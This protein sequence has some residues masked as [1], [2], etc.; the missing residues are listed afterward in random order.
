MDK[1]DGVQ[2][3]DGALIVRYDATAAALAAL[4]ERLGGVVYDCTDAK[5]DKAARQDRAELVRLGS[6]LE[7]KRKELKAPYLEL[8]RTIDAKAEEY[9]AE[10]QALKYPIDLQIKKEE[11]RKAAEKARA[12]A[13]EAA[14]LA[15]L[16]A[17]K[18]S[19]LHKAAPQMLEALKYVRDLYDPQET[20]TAFKATV[21]DA[22]EAAE[23]PQ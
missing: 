11:D 19:R 17:A 5:Q 15:D 18:L 12:E 6:A 23:G 2:Q 22:I 1:Q 13:A 4:K 16:E 10:I 7:A 21:N 14:R 3:I 20:S 9:D 8:G